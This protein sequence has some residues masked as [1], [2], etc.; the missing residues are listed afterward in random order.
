MQSHNPND[1]SIGSA[2]FLQTT[3]RCPYTLQWDA[4]FPPKFAP[5]HG[6]IWTLGPPESS[7]Q[8]ASRS[9]QP[10]L[11]GSRLTSVTDRQTDHATRSVTVGGLR[12][13]RSSAM[14]PNNS[15]WRLFVAV[16]RSNHIQSIAFSSTSYHAWRTLS[17]FRHVTGAVNSAT[18]KIFFIQ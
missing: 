7:T 5:S 13:V 17:V 8:T 2:V 16:K 6:G 14:R 9:V 15:N 11:Q 18:A 10:L 4:H 12:T 1:I 3:V